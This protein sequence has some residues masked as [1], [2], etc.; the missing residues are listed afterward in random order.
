M[1]CDARHFR[2]ALKVLNTAWDA[3]LLIHLERWEKQQ[4]NG[5]E[6]GIVGKN[7]LAPE[8]I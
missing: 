1:K 5:S 4:S 8:K 2:N 6:G 7:A 3:G